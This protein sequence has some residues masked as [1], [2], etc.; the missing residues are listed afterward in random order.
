MGIVSYLW[1]LGADTRADVAGRVANVTFH[2]PGT[3][4]VRLTVRDGSGNEDNDTALVTVLARGTADAGL[5]NP[6]VLPLLTLVAVNVALAWVVVRRRR[7]GGK[8]LSE[9]EA[10]E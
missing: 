3:V 4:P 9:A 10:F 5:A 1:D 6:L 2:Y 7:K 8:G